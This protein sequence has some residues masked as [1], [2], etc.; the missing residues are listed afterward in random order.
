LQ[1]SL[2]L[3][4]R[5]LIALLVLGCLLS[6]AA[7]AQP[8]G[9]VP[10]PFTA[11]YAVTFRG[12]GGGNLIMQWRHDAQSGH[13][14]FETRANPSTLAR[15]FVSGEAYERTTLEATNDGV[16]PILW[17]A[18]DGKSGDK[19]DG[20]L[21]FDWNAHK[22]TGTYEGK[23][24]SLP[25]EPGMQDRQSLQIGSMMSLLRGV[26]PTKIE[27]ING[28]SVRTY[29]YARVKTESITTKLGTFDTIVFESTRPGS[30]R[31]S[32]VWHAPAL[33]Y[34]PVRAE[35]V[36]KGKVETVM[37]LIELKKDDS[38]AK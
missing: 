2:S 12:I 24:V 4:A 7:E 35:Q 33:G 8:A 5:R 32:R 20:R 26:E 23:P 1:Q 19:N 36:R 31:V 29:T 21:E 38:A 13:Y 3:L 6:A 37:E 16:R 11:T 27:M 17:E 9:K 28:D 14:I 34:V 30:N 10:E 18:N 15:L 25:L 22:V